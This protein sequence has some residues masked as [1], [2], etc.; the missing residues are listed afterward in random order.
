MEDGLK[1]E[2]G[3]RCITAEQRC[4]CE[5]SNDCIRPGKLNCNKGTKKCEAGNFLKQF[6][7]N[8]LVKTEIDRR[9]GNTDEKITG[10]QTNGASVAQIYGD[11][12]RD[13]IEL[14]NANTLSLDGMAALNNAN[15]DALRSALRE[16]AWQKHEHVQWIMDKSLEMTNSLLE[17][18]R[19]QIVTRIADAVEAT[20]KAKD[21]EYTEAKERL[22][23]FT[24]NVSGL[25]EKYSL[26][27]NKMMKWFPNL[28]GP[29]I[30][31]MLHL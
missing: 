2:D 29:V 27:R 5:F 10:A 21:T 22:D 11:T 9:M 1:S 18:L 6:A 19:D 13:Y 25:R 20:E 15:N 28:L 8:S 31:Y 7:L 14:L 3:G 17:S 12:R 26:E 30:N 16:E 23:K 24:E 4:G